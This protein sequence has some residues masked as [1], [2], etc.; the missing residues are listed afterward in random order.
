MQTL[1]DQQTPPRARTT[2][3]LLHPTA[4]PGSPVCGSFGEPCRRWL[5]LLAESNIGVWQILPLAPPDPTGSPYSSPSCFALNP[6]FLDAA[7]LL[8]EGYVHADA[9][10]ALPGADAPLD[11]VGPLDFELAERRS[12]ALAAALLD[13]WPQQDQTRKDAF[14]NWCER[15]PW[16]EDHVH[17]MV[18]HLQYNDAWW[19]WPDPALARHDPSAL[20]SWAQ[21]CSSELLQER[22]LQWHLDRQW[23]A[24]HDLAAELGVVLFGDVPFYVSTD[25]ADVWSER[26]LFTVEADGRLITQSGVPPD[27]FS[28]TGQLWGSPVYRWWRHRLSRFRWWRRRISRQLALVDLLRLDHFRA[29]AGFWAVPGDNTTAEHGRW[30]R[31]PGRALLALLKR[32]RG[33]VLPLIAEDL[34]VITPDVESLRDDFALPGMKVLQFAFDGQQDNPYLPENIEGNRWVVY[35][36]T[37]DNPTTLGWWR[38]LDDAS[39]GRI[40]TRMKSAE[41]SPAWTLFDM[42]FATPAGLVVA[43]LQD[44]LHLDDQARFNTP[45]TSTGNWSWRLPHFNESLQGALGGYG[46]RGAVWGRSRAGA[47]GLRG[48]S[49]MR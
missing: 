33:G 24:I 22:L 21:T 32:D 6:W 23:Q 8:A 29:L 38:Q 12:R 4:L 1:M 9:I 49:A 2:G 45:G 18:L 44:L 3:V 48:A 13:A 5:K 40:S 20:R 11:G 42:A 27:Y 25:S 36:G 17:F 30:E 47:E 31:S 43:P 35:T 41:D 37:H 10:R 46:E 26:S 19:A 34:G 16:L 39:R 15:Q 14:Q 28:Q 7:D